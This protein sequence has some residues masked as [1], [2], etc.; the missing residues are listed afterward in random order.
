MFDRARH[1]ITYA[2]VTSTLALFLALGG[3]AAY[4]A[5]EWNGDNIQDESLTGADIRGSL[6]DLQNPN[7]V[8]GSL[9]TEDIADNTIF[10][11]DVA[12][13]SLT[14]AD[15]NFVGGSDISN[16]AVTGAHVA[17]DSLDGFDIQNLSGGDLIDGTVGSEDIADGSVGAD[18]LAPG[19]RGFTQVSRRRQHRVLDRGE[20]AHVNVTCPVGSVA[21]GGGF[22]H[23]GR[24]ADDIVF[25][26]SAWQTAR[27]WGVTAK[28]VGGLGSRDISFQAF[29]VC[30]R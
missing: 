5:N 3:G 15:I 21:T 25:Q 11:V 17:N 28:H 30:A 8:P 24:H 2:N 18:E 27:T 1:R 29:V 9:T 16:D 13:N 4:A 6:P 10:P 22:N 23:T 12:D 7:G 20:R 26:E 14:S 19:V